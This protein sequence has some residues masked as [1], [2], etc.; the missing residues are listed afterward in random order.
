[1]R[2]TLS[3]RGF[4]ALSSLV[5]S[6]CALEKQNEGATSSDSTGSAVDVSALKT[7]YDYHLADATEGAELIVACEEYNQSMVPESLNYRMQKKG[8]TLD[9]WKAF[10][11]KQTLDWGD[12]DEETMGKCLAFLQHCAEE[13]GIELP[14]SD[15]IIFVRTTGAEEGGSATGYTHGTQIYIREDVTPAF[16]EALEAI[17]DNSSQNYDRYFEFLAHELF[18]SLTRTHP[19]FRKKMYSIIGFDVADE[20]YE[21]GPSVSELIFANPDVEH[22]DSSAVFTI[23]GKQRRCAVVFYMKEPFETPGTNFFDNCSTGLV[24]I[25]DLD[26][27]YDYEEAS[28]FWEVFGRNTDYVIDPEECMADNFSF[29]LV[30]GLD[31]MDYETPRIIEEIIQALKA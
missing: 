20:D 13:R 25:D 18:H 12:G 31:G 7:S 9:E 24:P 23:D 5:L 8:A 6:G 21:F 4:L 2:K 26:K 22:H 27:L 15:E 29:M 16:S 1:M 28:D 11:A 3:R 19:D 17:G 14:D 30:H 10:A